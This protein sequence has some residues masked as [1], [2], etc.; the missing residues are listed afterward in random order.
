MSRGIPNMVHHTNR[1]VGGVNP[2]VMNRERREVR[3]SMYVL[4]PY[5]FLPPTTILPKKQGDKSV[6]KGRNANVAPFNL[7]KAVVDDNVVD[8]EVLIASKLDND[9][10]IFYENVDPTKQM[11]A[12]I[13]LLTRDRPH[14]ARFIVAKLGTTSLHLRSNMFMIETDPHIIGTLDGSMHPYPSWDD[15]D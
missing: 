8:D 3:P 13:E 14:G 6:N 2:N 7:G 4:S 11:N 1:D 15:V 9:D 10:Y 5:T 12:W